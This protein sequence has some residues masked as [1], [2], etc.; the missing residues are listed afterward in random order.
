MEFA[1]YVIQTLTHII[2]PEAAILPSK[3]LNIILKSDSLDLLIKEEI[4]FAIKVES[5]VDK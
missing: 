2:S 5:L 1:K 3:Q 4:K